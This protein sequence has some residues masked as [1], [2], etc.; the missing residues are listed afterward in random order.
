MN[1]AHVESTKLVDTLLSHQSTVETGSGTPMAA[2]LPAATTAGAREHR[3]PV[4]HFTHDS[5]SM[6]YVSSPHWL[7]TEALFNA[8]PLRLSKYALA[9]KSQSRGSAPCGPQTEAKGRH[10]L[11]SGNFSPGGGYTIADSARDAQKV[12]ASIIGHDRAS[13]QAQ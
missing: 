4:G 13:E 11:C 6:E 7:Q 5:P 2:P 12:S 9:H 3:A 8:H 10:Q 1:C